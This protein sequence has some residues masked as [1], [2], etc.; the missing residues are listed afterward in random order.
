MHSGGSP[1][2]S[3]REWPRYPNAN[4]PGSSFSTGSDGDGTFRVAIPK[5]KGS[6]YPTASNRQWMVPMEFPSMVPCVPA[7]DPWETLLGGHQHPSPSVPFPAAILGSHPKADPWKTWNWD[8]FPPVSQHFG[9]SAHASKAGMWFPGPCAMLGASQCIPLDWN[10][11]ILGG[12]L[13]PGWRLWKGNTSGL[14]AAASQSPSIPCRRSMPLE[15]RP[16][17]EVPIFSSSRDSDPWG[18]TDGGGSGVPGNPCGRA[19]KRD[20]STRWDGTLGKMEFPSHLPR[21]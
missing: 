16:A 13:F 15:S 9:L 8:A 2:L 14:D 4:P 1:R 5:G 7:R 3:Q 10:R 6:L 19:E 21:D 20:G 12:L 11:S 18:T 17:P